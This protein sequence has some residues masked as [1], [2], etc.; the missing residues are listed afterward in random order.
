MGCICGKASAIE[1]NRET[2]RL[3][4]A[5]AS[6]VVSAPAIASEKLPVRVNSHD[7]ERRGERQGYSIHQQLQAIGSIPK[8]M[9]GEQVTAGWPAWLVAVAGESIRGWVPRRAD[10]FEKLD[11]VSYWLSSS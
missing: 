8:A 3:R 7:A 5:L 6:H 11:K 4:P 1:D 10:S 2:P 9:E